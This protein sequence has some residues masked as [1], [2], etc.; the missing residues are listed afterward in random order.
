MIANPVSEKLRRGMTC[1]GGDD[2]RGKALE[3]IYT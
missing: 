2:C 3:F 1:E